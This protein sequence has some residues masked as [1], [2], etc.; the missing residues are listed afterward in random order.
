VH[1]VEN[2][3]GQRRFVDE[4]T[5]QKLIGEGWKPVADVPDPVDSAETLLTVGSNLALKLGLSKATESTPQSLADSR[6]LQIVATLAPS[7]GEAI[8]QLL[9]S[10]AVRGILTTIF[11]FTLYTS[12]SHPGHGLPEAVAVSTLALLV[13]VP[14]LTG[15]AQWWEILAI[16]AG[17]MLV[18]FGL[19]VF[20]GHFVSAI[21]GII[22]VLF[23]LT[24]T[25]VGR[26]PSGLPGFFPKLQGTWDSMGH[27]LLIVVGGMFCS[28]LLWMWLQRFLPHLPYFNRLIL[29][30]TSGGMASDGT[31]NFWPPIGSRGR[32]MTDL[33]PGGSAGFSDPAIGDVRITNVVSDSGF[34]DAGTDV[35]VREVEG[36]R[37]VV[38]A[39]NGL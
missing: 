36:N 22:L 24:M 25:F 4:P 15:Y 19:L 14:L 10:A 2:A 18:A 13:G 27:G 9:S 28:L 31:K 39:V 30:T 11:L 16:L 12:F 8:V 17:I 38:R 37:V 21:S 29:N 34:V 3:D 7:A 20:P 33:R 1:W 32:A 6:H 23:G 26:E 35:V 5:Y